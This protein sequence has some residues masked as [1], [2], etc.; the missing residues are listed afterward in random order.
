MNVFIKE[1]NFGSDNSITIDVSV[2]IHPK[3]E[4][5]NIGYLE[6]LKQSHNKPF[7]VALLRIDSENITQRHQVIK[8]YDNKK[9]TPIEIYPQEYSNG[10]IFGKIIDMP[11]R[12]L[13]SDTYDSINGNTYISFSV[14][15]KEKLKI[16]FFSEGKCCK[17]RKLC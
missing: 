2:S 13:N 9:D 17:N 10:N 1:P 16:S 4:D 5:K 15:P 12:E 6:L 11:C 3:G 7:S 8:Y 14:L